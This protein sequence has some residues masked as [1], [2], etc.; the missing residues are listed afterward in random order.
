MSLA[1]SAYVEWSAYRCLNRRTVAGIE[2]KVVKEG[3]RHA[4]AR[5][6]G[7]DKDKIAGWK[8]ELDRVLQVFNV[9]PF[10]SVGCSWT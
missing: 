4:A 9:S 7:G 6:M 8:Q 2:R 5:F 10:G 3:K 1:S